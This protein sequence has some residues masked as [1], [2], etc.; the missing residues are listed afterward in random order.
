MPEGGQLTGLQGGAVT[1]RE[2]GEG[3]EAMS[4]HFLSRLGSG[5]RFGFCPKWQCSGKALDLR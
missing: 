1:L 5:F 3:H 2:A 4:I